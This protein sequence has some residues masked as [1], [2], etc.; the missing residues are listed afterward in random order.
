MTVGESDEQLVRMCRDGRPDLFRHLVLR[1]ERALTAF[2]FGRLD[3]A[4]EVIEVAQEVM[5]RA[6]FALPRLRQPAA[7]SSWLMGIADHAAKEFQRTKRR[8]PRGREAFDL[9]AVEA[10]PET[11]P[12]P[13]PDR[14]LG[15]A[16]ACLTAEHR[17]VVLLRFYEG[18]S[19]VEIGVRLGMPVGS[20]TS[21]L[22]RAYTLLRASLRGPDR[23]S[24]PEP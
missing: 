11:D 13:D 12:D 10:R 15:R 16:L 22:S 18:M 2:L 3:N 19:C 9:D 7:F 8:D 14:A 4:D 1:H 6:Y 24:E 20:V 5:V 23:G 21:R 17:E